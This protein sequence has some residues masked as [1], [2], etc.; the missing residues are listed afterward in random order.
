MKMPIGDFETDAEHAAWLNVDPRTL[1]NWRNRPN[2]VL[3][4]TAGR[5]ILHKRE[6]TLA[7]L[8]ARKT[9][10]NPTTERR[11]GRPRRP[12]GRREQHRIEARS[13]P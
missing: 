2:G 3:Y 12:A 5:T 4:T 6:W 1:R 13:G 8:E 11:R 7:W 10:R 9:I